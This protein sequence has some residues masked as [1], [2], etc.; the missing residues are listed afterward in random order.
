[1]SPAF[2]AELADRGLAPTTAVL[3]APCGQLAAHTWRTTS[4]R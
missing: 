1:M 2:E 3:V 4:P